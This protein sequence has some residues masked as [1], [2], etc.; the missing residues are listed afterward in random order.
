MTK[1]STNHNELAV[2]TSQN[3][4]KAI[5]LPHYNVISTLE[6]P[7]MRSCITLKPNLKR[8]RISYSTGKNKV[9]KLKYLLRKYR[10]EDSEEDSEED[11]DDDQSSESYAERGGVYCHDNHIYFK[12]NVT[13][14]SV[15]ALTNIINKKNKVISDLQKIDMIKSVKPN[16]LYLHISSFG[17]SLFH[18]LIAVDAI[19][20]SLIPIYTI[21]DG[22]AASAASLMSVVGKKRYMTSHAYVLIHQLSS[23]AQGTFEQLR[24]FQTNNE[25][26]MEDMKKIYL[27]NTELSKELI[28]E[29]LKHDLWWRVD[30]C[31]ELGLVDE[32]YNNQ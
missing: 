16:P 10:M 27:D 24:D 29:A 31:I 8:K 26:I 18:G 11:S 4:R 13:A 28:D 3:N 32:I 19:K 23:G 1:S 9:P 30:K 5:I 12:T 25:N 20:N 15:D 14:S 2:R 22:Y 6:K 21:I 7:N 17:G